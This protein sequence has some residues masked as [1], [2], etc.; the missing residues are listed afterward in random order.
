MHALKT[1]IIYSPS[2]RGGE[3][4]WKHKKIDMVVTGQNLFESR[5]QNFK[6]CL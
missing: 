6:A 5:S 2:K 1:D 4:S 3:E